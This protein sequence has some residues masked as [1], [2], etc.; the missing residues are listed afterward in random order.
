MRCGMDIGRVESLCAS[1]SLTILVSVNGVL[2]VWVRILN[3]QFHCFVKQH[4]AHMARPKCQLLD[5][6]LSLTICRLGEA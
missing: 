5:K 6:E 4:N 3:R 1:I 2:P